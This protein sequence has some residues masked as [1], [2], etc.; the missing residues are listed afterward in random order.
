MPFFSKYYNSIKP[1]SPWIPSFLT[2]VHKGSKAESM[3]QFSFAAVTLM[4]AVMIPMSMDYV[5]SKERSKHERRLRMSPT[6][7]NS[8]RIEIYNDQMALRKYLD[9]MKDDEEEEV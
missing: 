1:T 2:K 3:F 7:D 6:M 8:L 9:D 4:I 5:M